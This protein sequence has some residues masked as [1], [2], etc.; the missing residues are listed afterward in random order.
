M[1]SS[2]NEPTDRGEDESMTEGAERETGDEGVEVDLDVTPQT[3]SRMTKVLGVLAGVAVVAL[4]IGGVGRL[5]G[6]GWFGY[7]T[8]M[9]EGGELYVLNSNLEPRYVSVD[10]LEPVEVP[11]KNA[12]RLDL[13]GGTSEV[14]ISKTAGGAP[15]ATEKI[16]VDKSHALLKLTDKEC[17]GVFDVGSYYTQGGD[18]IPSLVKKI[19]KGARITVL[20]SRN[21]VWPRK[22]FPKR[23]QPS[24]GK[25]LAVEIVGCDL[26]ED[27]EFLVSYIGHQIAERF[28]KDQEAEGNSEVVRPRL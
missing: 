13:I 17:L 5:S 15:L 3:P 18:G 1:T 28:K 4:I 19:D 10:G 12:Q 14:T 9:Y 21:I 20:D 26:F 11:A 23:V 27:E 8:W 24:D 6:T 7:R 22:S 16:T 2:S 25:L